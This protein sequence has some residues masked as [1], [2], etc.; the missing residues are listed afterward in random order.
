M[1]KNNLLKSARK[2]EEEPDSWISEPRRIT[3]DE[4][5]ILLFEVM[6]WIELKNISIDMIECET[7]LVIVLIET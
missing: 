3:N 4:F 7:S 5:Q 2:D 6:E 1:T